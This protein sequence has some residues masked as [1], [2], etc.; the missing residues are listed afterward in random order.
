MAPKT[1]DSELDLKALQETLFQIDLAS[2]HRSHSDTALAGPIF[3]SRFPT[4]LQ[5]VV[6]ENCTLSSA[7]ALSHT[8]GNLR[9]T[10][11]TF[12][13]TIIGSVLGD[14]GCKEEADRL[15]QAL[16]TAGSTHDTYVF[17]AITIE[18]II[19]PLLKAICPGDRHHHHG[20]C[21]RC[22]GLSE[23]DGLRRLLYNGWTEAVKNGGWPRKMPF[24]DL[25][26]FVQKAL[27]ASVS[28]GFLQI[29]PSPR[30]SSSLTKI[31]TAPS[32][33]SDTA[34]SRVSS[35]IG[36]SNNTGR[37]GNRAGRH[38]NRTPAPPPGPP[39]NTSSPMSPPAETRN[40]TTAPTSSRS[41]R[42]NSTAAPANSPI[43]PSN[44]TNYHASP[45]TRRQNN[46][47]TY[48]QT[49]R[50]TKPPTSSRAPVNRAVRHIN[51]T[52]AT[53]SLP[54]ESSSP[55]VTQSLGN[56]TTPTVPLAARTNWH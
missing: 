46:N 26:E 33:L 34:V 43:G 29:N 16:L 55:A 38:R 35:G 9:R 13:P 50:Q 51:S 39:N 20:L 36:P 53:V 4:E 8:C 40:H 3:P 23:K 11:Q 32:R 31:P 30:P 1:R 6:F 48:G 56:N 49:M 44:S 25:A 15:H 24:R 10:F 22:W 2:T 27:P 54:T 45:P 37:N 14:P 12:K 17:P 41:R 28:H 19:P 18:R 7:L 42:R 52:S 47:D 21:I 5:L